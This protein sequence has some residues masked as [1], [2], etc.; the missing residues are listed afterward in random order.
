MEK[1]VRC[2]GGHGLQTVPLAAAQEPE[3]IALPRTHTNASALAH[4]I[5]TLSLSAYSPL[6]PLFACEGKR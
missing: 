6:P 2:D 1:E 3:V 5:F 4:S